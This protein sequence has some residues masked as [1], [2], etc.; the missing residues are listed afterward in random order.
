[1]SKSKSKAK[2]FKRAYRLEWKLSNQKESF[3]KL[4][5]ESL[6]FQVRT[7]GLGVMEDGYKKESGSKPDFLILWNNSKLCYIEVTGDNFYDHSKEK[8]IIAD[9]IRKAL[10]I[11]AAEGLPTIFIYL[12]LKNGKLVEACFVD[13]RQAEKYYADEK[14]HR[15]YKTK[16][17]TEEHF[18]YIPDSEW[19]P[20]SNLVFELLRLRLGVSV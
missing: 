10:F 7:T 11:E 14:Y 8:Y 6:G 13:L 17:G 1:M 20:L 2:R 12:G 4:L 3:I 15:F 9:K 18:V 19:R 5:F 16:W